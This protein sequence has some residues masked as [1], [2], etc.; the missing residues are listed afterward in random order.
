MCAYERT[1]EPEPEKNPD[2]KHPGLYILTADSFERRVIL[3]EDNFFVLVS[4]DW[5]PPSKQMKPEWYQLAKLL[6]KE[7]KVPSYKLVALKHRF[8]H[9][10]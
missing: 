3:S 9:A 1:R 7:K 5:C 10:R 4:A 6:A 2:P 8:P